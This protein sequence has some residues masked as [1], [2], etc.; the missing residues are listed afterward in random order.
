MP[1]EVPDRCSSC[2]LILLRGHIFDAFDR[3]EQYGPI[4]RLH[5]EAHQK[6]TAR[7][8]YVGVSSY[9]D[10]G[11]PWRECYPALP[12]LRDEI[13]SSKSEGRQALPNEALQRTRLWRAA[14]FRR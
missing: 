14:E 2:G 5:P 12:S 3:A 11:G 9:Y 1:F 8:G 13:Q 7:A 4:L 10:P 6:E